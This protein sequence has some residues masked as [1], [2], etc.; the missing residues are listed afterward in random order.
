[1]A[2]TDGYT[3]L[4]ALKLKKL[5]AILAELVPFQHNIDELARKLNISRDSIYNYR[6]YL[7]KA[8]MINTLHAKGKGISL[9]QKPEKIYLKNTNLSYALQLEPNTGSIRECFLLNQ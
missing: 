9:L 1:M 7:K 4:T 5:L 2:Y 8:L 3:P 6:K